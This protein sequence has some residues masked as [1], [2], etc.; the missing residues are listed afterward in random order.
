MKSLPLPLFLC[1]ILFPGKGFAQIKSDSILVEGNYRSFYFNKP[2]S[3]KT[4]GS[5]IFVLHGSGGNGKNMMRR[6][7]QLEQKAK[8]ENALVIYPNGYKKYWNECRKVASSLAN[9]ENINEEAF[10]SAMINYFKNNY[11]INEK[12]VFAMGMSGGG[13]MC[14]KLAMTMPGKFRA[15]MAL[16]ANLPDDQNMDCVES[17]V[18]IPVMIVNGTADPVNPYDGGLMPAGSFVMGTVRSTEQTFQY[19]AGLADYKGDPTKESIPNNDPSDG[20]TIERYTYNAKGKPE[21]V[22]LKVIGGKHDEPNDI[23]VYVEGWEFFKRQLK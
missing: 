15:V 18:S 19:W 9:K 17:K 7:S 4:D 22:L 10:F 6:T 16:I 5:L 2:E 11:K 12:S 14:Y 23:N 8:A 21:I 13:H 1:C 3:L 20:R